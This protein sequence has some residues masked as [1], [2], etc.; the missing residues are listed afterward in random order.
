LRQALQQ[1]GERLYQ[2]TLG[3]LEIHPVPLDEA[4]RAMLEELWAEVKP[5]S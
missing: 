2:A 3:D 5:Q 1:G 4:F